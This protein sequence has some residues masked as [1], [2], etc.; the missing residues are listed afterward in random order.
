M[1]LFWFSP[2]SKSLCCSQDPNDLRTGKALRDGDDLR[3]I[4]VPVIGVTGYEVTVAPI[5]AGSPEGGRQPK[6]WVKAATYFDGLG[7]E[8]AIID[9]SRKKQVPKTELF[10]PADGKRQTQFKLKSGMEGALC[11]LAADGNGEL[12]DG[13]GGLADGKGELAYKGNYA[14]GLGGESD[15][16]PEL[17]SEPER[18]NDPEPAQGGPPS[19]SRIGATSG[20]PRYKV[21]PEPRRAQSLNRIVNQRRTSE[22]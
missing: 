3:L 17:E 18:E 1:F 21:A 14:E 7:D 13:N 16:G 15:P 2:D 10:W 11:K 22:R 6:I 5:V 8:N 4:M 12:V 20:R 9:L 19:P